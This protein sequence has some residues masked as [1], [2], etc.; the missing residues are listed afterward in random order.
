LDDSSKITQESNKLA[1][2]GMEQ[3]ALAQ[4]EHE[5]PLS[6]TYLE[7]IQ[8]YEDAEQE[9][10]RELEEEIDGDQG[11]Q[12][13][14]TQSSDNELFW[15]GGSTDEGLYEQD[16]NQQGGEE[17]DSTAG[18]ES[19][20]PVKLYQAEGQADCSDGEG[21]NPGLEHHDHLHVLFDDLPT[22][23]PYQEIQ[24]SQQ[25]DFRRFRQSL[26]S[27]FY[28]SIHPSAA[29]LPPSG[30]RY[31]SIYGNAQQ[32]FFQPP[33][34]QHLTVQQLPAE[35]F[36][37]QQLPVPQSGTLL[38]QATI[39]PRVI[40]ATRPSQR[41]GDIGGFQPQNLAQ[42]PSGPIPNAGATTQPPSAVPPRSQRWRSLPDGP[43]LRGT[44]TPKVVVRNSFLTR[45]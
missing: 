19:E 23:Y 9:E 39:Q 10:E 40:R 29:L 15:D 8:T 24:N 27:W 22:D 35:Q 21:N 45:G 28:E 37:A 20:E 31:I 4:S 34:G 13:Q 12:A 7:G 25:D 41:G 6:E 32:P 30:Q 36:G 16:L 18:Q 33:V 11:H 3:H 44:K 2:G 26:P 17:T 14:R 5:L 1:Q 43:Y 38:P 42:V